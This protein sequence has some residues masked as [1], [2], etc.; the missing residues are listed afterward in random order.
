MPTLRAQP[1]RRRK[2]YEEIVE[3]LEAMMIAG[4]LAP[5]D[6]LPP[7]RE[8]VE[9]FQV[10]RTAVREALFALQ[11][12]GLVALKNGERAYV[13][14]PSAETLVGELSGAVRHM[15]AHEDG[16]RDFQGA[17]LLFE[18]SLAR[19]AALN[20]TAE[21]LGRLERALQDNREAIGDDARFNRTDVHF[22]FVL[23]EI[24]RN[25]VLTTL[26]NAVAAW[27]AEQR[28]TSTRMEGA[29]QAAY[30]A[31]RKIFDAI[32]AQDPDR[33]ERAMR[34]HLIEVS[35]YYW[36]ARSSEDGLR[37]PRRL[38]DQAGGQG[39]LP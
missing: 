24:A 21:D 4:E 14:R 1:I 6:Q 30:A 13:T 32:Q 27:L 23:T 19:H 10:G 39:A 20:R 7:E 33:A 16:M 37:D 28:Q 22:H 12:M 38:R 36:R 18:T 2:L 9:T 34:D 25:A 26:H 31:H 15:L 3:R 8:L 35:H 5:G 29:A 11:R 17:R